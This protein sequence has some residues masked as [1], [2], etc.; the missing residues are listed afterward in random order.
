M[1]KQNASKST[2]FLMELTAVIFIF[3]L[4][5]AVCLGLFAASQRMTEDSDNL[6]Y[7]VALSKTA[8]SCYKA[9]DG[10]LSEILQLMGVAGDDSLSD[11]VIVYYNDRWQPIEKPSLDGF[12]LQVKALSRDA[13]SLQEADVAVYDMQQTQIFQL[14]VKKMVPY[15]GGELHGS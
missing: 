12:Y 2:L 4:C 1:R 9:A 6:N 8:A 11:S 3:A 13:A 14:Q 10:D 5:A 7:A 15:A